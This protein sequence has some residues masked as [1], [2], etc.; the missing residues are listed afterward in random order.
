MW[1]LL[2]LIWFPYYAGAVFYFLTI[3]VA[4]SVTK[5]N[6]SKCSLPGRSECTVQR[7]GGAERRIN[8]CK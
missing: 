1:E 7:K 3:L 6:S 4:E 5:Y 8:Y 2:I